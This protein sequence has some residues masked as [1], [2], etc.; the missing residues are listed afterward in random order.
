ME[1]FLLAT[2][3]IALVIA[4]VMS[5]VAAKV[6][7]EERR[8]SSARVAALTAAAGIAPPVVSSDEEPRR[9]PWAKSPAPARA[10]GFDM[11]EAREVKAAAPV[12]IMAPPP[13]PEIGA[14]ELPLQHGFLNGPAT[15]R[16]SS[17]GQRFLALAAAMLFVV[18]ATGFIWQWSNSK[19]STAS[20]A[21]VTTEPLE[22]LSL[23]HDRQSS[24]L[25]VSGLVR[26][27][28][29]GKAVEHLSAVVFLFDGQGTFVTSAKAPVDF[30][31]LSSG[32]ESP[33]VVT[34]DAPA[35]VAR[36]RVSFRT[37]EGIMPHIDRRGQ[38][39][40]AGNEE[41]RIKK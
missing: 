29:A 16:A 2:T 20:A 3:I 23:R 18:L 6:S 19:S 21:V 13:V 25:S 36:Y 39:P 27:P 12:E 31:K 32:D 8:R 9:A 24:K 1:T 17:G 26:N 15:P 30:V 10:I 37:D 38:G 22:L 35:S 7:R 34:L 41:V 5:V 4:L 40:G 11:R 14:I 33:F 28:V